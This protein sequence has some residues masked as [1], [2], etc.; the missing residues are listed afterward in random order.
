[1]WTHPRVFVRYGKIIGEIRVKKNAE[2]FFF[3]GLDLVWEST[4]PH[5]GKLSP[6]KLSFLDIP[7][8]IIVTVIVMTRANQTPASTGVSSMGELQC[9]RGESGLIPTTSSATGRS[10][11]CCWGCRSCC[12]GWWPADPLSLPPGTFLT[13]WEEVTFWEELW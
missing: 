9:R 12:G 1:M 3:M 5:L 11:C 6:K 13:P 2:W 7:I 10:C 8:S 4:H